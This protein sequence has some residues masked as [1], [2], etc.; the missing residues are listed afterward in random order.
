MTN[1]KLERVLRLSDKHPAMHA[2]RQTL[3]AY[4]VARALLL[5]LLVLWGLG[6]YSGSG[7]GFSYVGSPVRSDTPPSLVLPE[8]G[9]GTSPPCPRGRRGRPAA[10][11]T[12]GWWASPPPRP[13]RWSR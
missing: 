8:A 1:P 5:P 3:N 10:T 11:T 4:V 7:Q 12:A 6:V 9:G 2:E 13:R